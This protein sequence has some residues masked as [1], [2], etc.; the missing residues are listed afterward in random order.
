MTLKTR[1]IYAGIPPLT[2]ALGDA[3]A[4]S[5]CPPSRGWGGSGRRR[6]RRRIDKIKIAVR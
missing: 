1:T 2:T 4:V 3:K 6:K 5:A